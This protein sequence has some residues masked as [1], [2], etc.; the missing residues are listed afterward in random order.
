MH[1]CP[2]LMRQ[3]VTPGC[4]VRLDCGW[5]NRTEASQSELPELTDDILSQLPS[6]NASSAVSDSQRVQSAS[7]LLSAE[8]PPR[9]PADQAMEVQQAELRVRDLQILAPSDAKVRHLPCRQRGASANRLVDESDPEQ[10]S[11]A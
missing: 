8:E 6:A 10:V 5:G 3:S 4:V 7:N 1:I 11:V 9:L 2:L